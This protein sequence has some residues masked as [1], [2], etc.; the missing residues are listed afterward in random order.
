MTIG[1]AESGAGRISAS[2]HHVL[3]GNVDVSK[4]ALERRTLV[5]G[6]ASG[7]LVHQVDGL[8]GRAGSVGRGQANVATL[9]DLDVA[10]RDR[11]L[12]GLVDGLL[13][14]SL[15]CTSS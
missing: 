6:T 12:P 9:I 5:D 13:T 10:A 4:E 15:N 7:E 11:T 14:S 1:T 2:S 8:G 3:R